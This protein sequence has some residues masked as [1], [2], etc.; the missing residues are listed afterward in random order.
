MNTYIPFLGRIFMCALFFNSVFSKIADPAGLATT[1]AEKGV[2]LADVTAWFV[3]IIELLAPILILIGYKTRWAAF[4]LAFWLLLV[5]IVMHPITDAKQKGN[6]LK[7]FALI[8]GLLFVA[9]SG[10]GKWSLDRS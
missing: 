2:P 5:T 8:G 3:I 7:N 6:F 9:R 4:A 10:A 1:L